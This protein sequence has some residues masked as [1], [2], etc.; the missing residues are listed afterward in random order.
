M[1]DLDAFCCKIV[2][3]CYP[4]SRVIFSV[5]IVMSQSSESYWNRYYLGRDGF[6]CPS[7][8][9]A[10]ILNEFSHKRRFI[11]IGCG[12]GR[13]SLFFASYG[14]KVLGIDGSASAVNLCQEKAS[15]QGL[16]ESF[17]SGLDIYD[18]EKCENFV[19]VHQDEWLGALIYA[20]FFL[21]AIDDAAERNFLKLASDLVGQK[22]QLC[23]EFRTHR[24]EFQQKE[25]AAHYRR[26]IESL[27]FLRHARAYGFDCIYSAEGFGFAK[28]KSDDAHVA[29]LILEK[30]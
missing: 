12:D 24:D 23:L 28:Y 21:H 11:D 18:S 17:F 10:F 15:K 2:M 20:R 5:G 30:Q 25:T 7:Q 13:D 19:T 14:M 4:N 8:F 27:T 16:T 29:R 1:N 26:Y 9:A 22:G 3:I 6:S